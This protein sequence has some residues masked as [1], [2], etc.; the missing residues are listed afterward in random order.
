MM[1]MS[2]SSAPPTTTG[3]EDDR[4]SGPGGG[5]DRDDDD[6][7]ND[8]DVPMSLRSPLGLPPRPVKRSGDSNGA[9]AGGAGAAPRAA[10]CALVVASDVLRL[11]AET[12]FAAACLVH[13]YCICYCSTHGGGSGGAGTSPPPPAPPVDWKWVVPACLFLACKAEEQHRRLR[14]VIN[15]RTG[16]RPPRSYSLLAVASFIIIIII[17]TATKYVTYQ[18]RTTLPPNLFPSLSLYPP[19]IIE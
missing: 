3:R 9:G 15:V 7:E 4:G 8:D 10:I 19:K 12:Q 6:D 14:D 16:V 17:I 18:L 1:M 11:S 2:A 5:G 13:R